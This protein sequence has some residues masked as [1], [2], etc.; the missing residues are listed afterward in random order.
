MGRVCDLSSPMERNSSS[1]T[2]KALTALVG[3]CLPIRVAPSDTLISIY[4]RY[5]LS[6]HLNARSVYLQTKNSYIQD[7]SISP[8]LNLFNPQLLFSLTYGLCSTNLSCRERGRVFTTRYVGCTGG[9]Q[10]FRDIIPMEDE[11]IQ[12]PFTPLRTNGEGINY[13]IISTPEGMSTWF[14]SVG[15]ITTLLDPIWPLEE[16]FKG[17]HW[18]R[19]RRREGQRRGMTRI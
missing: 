6:H 16:V 11:I 19:D 13:P 12:S 14:V 18:E 10:S 2:G 7:I 9:W 4:Q 15:T 5:I 8:L 3:V 17:S 1:A